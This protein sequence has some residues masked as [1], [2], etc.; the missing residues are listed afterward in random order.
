[1]KLRAAVLGVAL[2]FAAEAASAGIFAKPNTVAP[3]ATKA[4][5]DAEAQHQ[6]DYMLDMRLA[7]VARVDAIADKLLRA[8]ADLCPDTRAKL[9]FSAIAVGDLK[10]PLGDAA[11]RRWG[12]SEQLQ[13]ISVT[14]EGAAR[15]AGLQIG[16]RLESLNGSPVETG[17]KA[18]AN[19][20]RQLAG[21]LE[22]DPASVRLTVR[23]AGELRAIEIAPLRACAYDV[24]LDTEAKEINAY[25][26]GKRIV[27]TRPM[28]RLASSDPELALVIAHELAH[29]AK[30]HISAQRR[31]ATVG[32]LGGAAVDILIAAT[33]GVNTQGAFTKA[34]GQ[35]G[36]SAYSPE[37]ESEADYVGL[38]FMARAGFPIEGAENFWRKMGAEHPESIFLRGSHPPTSERYLAIAAAREEISAKIAAMA[39]LTPNDGSVKTAPAQ[40]LA[41]MGA[42]SKPSPTAAPPTRADSGLGVAQ[43][44]ITAPPSEAADKAPASYRAPSVAPAPLAIRPPS[45]ASAQSPS[46]E[47]MRNRNGEIVIP[48]R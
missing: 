2:A 35:V 14:P 4:A 31:N 47:P 28:Y 22:S 32:M 13:V 25:A 7:E 43:A 20:T 21:V 34:G 16:D 18:L 40:S 45:A 3:R 5:V 26:D 9:G 8:N 37:F 12:A 41:K 11:V 19:W 17:G 39:S 1:M 33:T 44:A 38:Y 15:A 29:D 24:V 10:G 27:V 30:R 23:R 46:D 6:V 48:R 42:A 36:A